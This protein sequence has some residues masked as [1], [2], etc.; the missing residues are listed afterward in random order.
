MK[1]KRRIVS[2]LLAVLMVLSHVI[3]MPLTAVAASSASNDG[4]VALDGIHFNYDNTL[5][6]LE[7]GTYELLIKAKSTFQMEETNVH[8]EFS[9]DGYYEALKTGTYLIELW[10]GDGA[11]TGQAPG[12]GGIGGEGGH[13]YGTIE[14][15]KG[16]I[17]FY[18]LGG[19]GKKTNA[20]GDGGGA[21]GPG[22]THG[23]SGNTTVGGGGGYSAVYLFDKAD[24][25]ARYLDGSG[26][27]AKT[28]VDESDRVSKYIM[29][30][31][32][33]GGAGANSQDKVA[34]ASGGAGGSMSG[35][36]ITL[37][38]A[39]YDVE[40]TCY[41]GAGGMSSGGN[42]NFTGK[43]GGIAPG[44]PKSSALGFTDTEWPN[45][46]RGTKNAN[47]GG[48][49]GG[50]GNLRGGGGGAGFCGGSGGIMESSIWPE[51]VGGGGG[52]SSF[53]S[54]QMSMA[55]D[56]VAQSVLTHENP[57]KTGG[58]VCITYIEEEEVNYLENLTLRFSTSKYMT[59]VD[60][61]ATTQYI[62]PN[63]YAVSQ[64]VV[65][66]EESFN[67]E[68]LSEILL[69]GVRACIGDEVSIRITFKPLLNFV[70]GNNVPLFEHGVIYVDTPDS[71]AHGSGEIQPDEACGYV[72]VPLN[73]PVH[74]LN[75]NTNNPGQSH[76]VSHLYEDVYADVRT[77]LQE[78]SNVPNEYYFIQ[79]IGEHVVTD[80]AGNV[81][82]GT[83][84]PTETTQYLVSLT[85]T[86]KPISETGVAAVGTPVTT[87]TFV[88]VA[89]VTVTGSHIAVLNGNWVTYT[90]SL[91]FDEDTKQFIL[92]LGIKSDTKRELEKIDPLPFFTYSGEGSEGDSDQSGTQIK[93]HTVKYTGWYYLELWGG[94]G[95]KGGESSTL[96]SDGGAGG[97]G[98]YV[99]GY[100]RLEEGQVLHVHIGADGAEGSPGSGFLAGGKG[101]GGGMPSAI[102]ILET[103]ENGEIKTD[104]KGEFVIDHY[105]AIAGGGG[106]GSGGWAGLGKDG[107]PCETTETSIPETIKDLAAV[108]AAYK[109]GNGGGAGTSGTAGKSAYDGTIYQATKPDGITTDFD[110]TKDPTKFGAGSY[111]NNGGGA[112]RL[113]YVALDVLGSAQTETLQ[114][115]G[116][117]VAL[118]K[119]FELVKHDVVDNITST[120]ILNTNL[121][122]TEAVTYTP[123][124]IED[125]SP[126]VSTTTVGDKKYN[127]VKF[128]VNLYI[129]PREE[130]PDSN[131]FVQKFLGGNDVMLV[132][133]SDDTKA[134][135]GMPTGIRF[136]QTVTIQQEG[137]PKE[138]IDSFDV[139]EE[140]S[141]D[142]AN[143][144]IQWDALPEGLITVR[145]KVHLVDESSPV[146]LSQLYSVDETLKNQLLDEFGKYESWCKDYIM[147]LDK[148]FISDSSGVSGQTDSD[149]PLAPDVTTTYKISL[150]IVPKSTSYYA[151]QA[152]EAQP[153]VVTKE[154][155]I[156]AAH[157]VTFD[158]ASHIHVYAPQV[159]SEEYDILYPGEN[160]L[161]IAEVGK[162]F[163]ANL[164]IEEGNFSLPDH[165]VVKIGGSDGVELVKDRDYTYSKETETL[166][167]F[168]S[169]ITGPLYIHAEETKMQYT[170]HYLVQKLVDGV[171]SKTEVADYSV[172]MW[173]GDPIPADTHYAEALAHA[174][175][176]NTNITGYTFT[177]DWG[178][179]SITPLTHMP[180]EDWWVIGSFVPNTYTLTIR[181]VDG[182]G[183]KIAEPYSAEYTFGDT[184][185]VTSPTIDGYVT[186]QTSVTQV[187]DA[188]FVDEGPHTIDVVYKSV[189]D[190]V[191]INLLREDGTVADTCTVTFNFGTKQYSYVSANSYNYTISATFGGNSVD[192]V[193]SLPAVKGHH[194]ENATTLSD[195]LTTG[196]GKTHEVTYRANRYFLRFNANGGECGETQ[197]TVVYGK[198]YNYDGTT[199]RA[200]PTP[201]LVGSKFLG[202]KNGSTTV[203][204]TEN[205]EF[206]GNNGDVITLTASWE[207]DKFAVEV[208]YVYEDG[209]SAFETQNDEVEYGASYTYNAPAI[210]GHTATP[211][212]Y[213]GIMPAQNLVLV[214]TYY[215]DS[216]LNELSVTVNWG[217]LNFTATYGI[218]NP[219]ELQY[220][221]DT[222]E[223]AGQNTVSVE[224]TSSVGINAS[225][226]YAAEAGYESIEG[227]FT[228]D[229]AG[230]R[231]NNTMALATAASST[232]Y[233]WIGGDIPDNMTPDSPTVC[234]Q[235][236]V[237]VTPQQQ[238]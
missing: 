214:F 2:M 145:N 130:A 173:A 215:E 50:A 43:G 174:G 171:P 149:T 55:L 38:G 105:I 190:Q 48:G 112:F 68:D 147:I 204:E 125:I 192:Y 92:S 62:D 115:Y 15:N 181:Y 152:A 113:N 200:F 81:Q 12:S 222:F 178:D 179:G 201:I 100:F 230:V 160:P 57:S 94:D 148:P 63:T 118:S 226:S 128:T 126:A 189:Q 237:T 1:I 205:V 121:V 156:F 39:G 9:E 207:T 26:N 209:T 217:N 220:G 228:T 34:L 168:A 52:G 167:V 25:T 27:L 170:L 75:H 66:G 42:T 140:P 67:K 153:V 107:N 219:E 162:D 90:K 6:V 10:G 22:G 8:S 74:V 56:S 206:A 136:S 17:L 210:S 32:G 142:Y 213:T 199:Y 175:I 180:V 20:W 157:R 95:G 141:T 41:P 7:D 233:V 21:N 14:L 137:Q 151:K 166:T 119:Y 116:L 47:L 127:E 69:Q 194:L 232:L 5:S 89:T 4:Y 60:A 59:V 46:W 122:K 158:L 23:K 202:W 235:V 164:T 132:D 124:I 97:A 30:A 198:P 191:V 82:T 71:N 61:T 223:P 77:A 49:A 111:A 129:K 29:I 33:G 85:V 234:G 51:N 36:G 193:I 104:S 70:G 86:P 197:R 117:S 103:D 203:T 91:E 187:I 99:G 73:F 93:T 218:W 211:A 155:T 182:E 195:T 45:D 176:T 76:E 186:D 123:V 161:Y 108:E 110:P 169:S 58:A 238:P 196:A 83:V 80:L 19:N 106:G 216:A 229:A 96:G 139:M 224:N 146:T 163:V 16:D 65:Q 53:I 102:A 13:I 143:V 236:T 98:G 227:Y 120:P 177:W 28:S 165:V 154:V 88:N 188:A 221:P 135:T 40:G 159:K 54:S 109:G 185:Q 133:V 114:D 18:S 3:C 64:T 131:G 79:S 183:N 138:I 184:A 101:G 11:T 72:N 212:Q 84:S 134:T 37:S 225:L 31:G 35:T 78:S 144:P 44:E 172:P 150:G 208:Q 24:F 87:Q 231:K